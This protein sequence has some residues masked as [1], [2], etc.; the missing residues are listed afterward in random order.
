L[1]QDDYHLE[2]LAIWACT[3]GRRFPDLQSKT[4]SLLAERNATGADLEALIAEVNSSGAPPVGGPLNTNGRTDG[5]APTV[6]ERMADILQSEPQAMWWMA[7]EWAEKLGMSAT[8]VTLSETWMTTI[9]YSRE[10]L[11]G[12]RTVRRRRK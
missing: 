9:K 2:Q 11:K 8:T 10:M 12:H 5:R 6:N 4:Q 3:S 1:E 7:K